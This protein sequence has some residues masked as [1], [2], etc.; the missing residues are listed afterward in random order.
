MGFCPPYF[1]VFLHATML[2]FLLPRLLFKM[3]YLLYIRIL[4]HVIIIHHTFIYS[5]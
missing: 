4:L 3:I 2:L 5:Q 1:S